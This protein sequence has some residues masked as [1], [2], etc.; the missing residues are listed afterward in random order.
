VIAAAQRRA[1]ETAAAELAARHAPDR[2]IDPVTAILEEVRR[3]AG[4]V[5]WLRSQVEALDPESLVRGTRTV[6]RVDGPD[7]TTTTTEA[8]PGVHL[9]WR[10]Y[11]QERDRLR[12]VCRDAISAG[13]AERQVRLA[14]RQGELL[15]DGLTWLLRELGH[16]GDEHATATVV[17]MLTAL[18]GGQVPEGD[19]A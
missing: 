16:E 2:D 14:E 7:G 6:R 8:G 19:V 10:L 9:W 17:R 12:M 4:T 11:G 13:I 5:E 18:D 3:C 15:A 1:E